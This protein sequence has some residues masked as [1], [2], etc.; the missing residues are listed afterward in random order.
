MLQNVSYEIVSLQ[1]ASYEIVG[2]CGN[3][4]TSSPQ[5]RRFAGSNPTEV[6]RFFR[7]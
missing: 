5:G 3:R 1:K 6:D 7:T 4:V 2:L